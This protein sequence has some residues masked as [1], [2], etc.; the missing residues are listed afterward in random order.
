MNFGEKQ[1]FSTF[2]PVQSFILAGFLPD[3]RIYMSM[4]HSISCVHTG[5]NHFEL[6]QLRTLVTKNKHTECYK[7]NIQSVAK[8]NIQSVTKINIQSVRKINIQ[9]VTKTKTKY[10]GEK[11]NFSTFFPVYNLLHH[12]P[13]PH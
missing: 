8:T 5:K 1:N 6:F 7:N 12:H 10:F 11:L 4:T 2:F 13:S 9:S 3:R